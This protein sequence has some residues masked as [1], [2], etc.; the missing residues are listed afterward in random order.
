M[1]ESLAPLTWMFHQRRRQVCWG[2][3]SPQEIL[4]CMWAVCVTPEPNIRCVES[5]SRAFA[6]Q[7]E[8]N[9]RRTTW[10]KIWSIWIVIY[11]QS[12]DIN[13]CVTSPP[14]PSAQSWFDM[15]PIQFGCAVP[16]TRSDTLL[17]VYQ[18]MWS[19]VK[20]V[21]YKIQ[22]RFLQET[23]QNINVHTHARFQ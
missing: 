9:Q 1:I 19:P 11:Y 16:H 22:L 12:A 3:R 8:S 10:S 14:P 18:S 4:V 20:C 15:F 7:S 17:Y 6:R 5:S 13:M 21:R 23:N 2:N